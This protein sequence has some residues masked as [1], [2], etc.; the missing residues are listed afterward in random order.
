ME[1]TPEIMSHGILDE[2]NEK[3]H[4]VFL[5]VMSWGVYKKN[6]SEMPD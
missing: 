6:L 3:I 1:E 2:H 4:A 5:C